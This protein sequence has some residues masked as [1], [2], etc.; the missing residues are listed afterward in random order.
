M[1]GEL[2]TTITFPVK[3][4]FRYI[5]LL[6]FAPALII[7]C[8]K[9]SCIDVPN[10]PKPISFSAGVSTITKAIKPDD[11]TV[12]LTVGNEVSIFAT[13]EYNDVPEQ[14]FS[15]L[16]LHCDAVPNPST[17]SN[18]LSSAWTYSPVAYWKDNGDYYFSG[19]FT[20]SS[21][22]VSIDNTYT[23][24]V[25]Y[26]A[27][28]NT[29]MM[30]ARTHQDAAVSKDPVNLTFKHTTSAVRFLFGKSSS[31]DS[32]QYT[33][34]SFQLENIIGVGEFSM[35]TR[36]TGSPTI[37]SSNWSTGSSYTTLFEWAAEQV[38]D[39]KAITH[40]S[41]VDDP[42]GYTPMGW[43]Y[44]VPQSLSTDAAVRFSVSY[45][46]G[47]PVETV[48]NFYGATDQISESGIAWA[49]NQVYNYF[50]TLNQSGLDLTIQA[51]PWD[52]IQVT[53]DDFNFE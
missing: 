17:P 7:S 29:D 10:G 3:M 11:P 14:V 43:Y 33:L 49:P 32:D 40:P 48:L 26:S 19:V 44:M 23:L 47:A 27:G 50:I 41:D 51:I 15:N 13:R 12:L 1:I 42:D 25:S 22:K 6:A 30:V 31:S 45:N 20:Y 28:D 24:K 18:P 53:T 38:E 4:K 39:R 46:G 35:A 8:G 34:T 52:E 9:D 16:A 37:T 21:D 5:I 36:V 2:I